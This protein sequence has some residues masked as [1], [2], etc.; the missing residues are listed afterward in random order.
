MDDLKLFGKSENQIDSL[1]W[2]EYLFS[3]G[4]GMEFG[5][6]KCAVVVLKRGKTIKFDGIQLP[7]EE[8]MK[9]VDVNG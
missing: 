7:N 9:G 3:E 2:T 4:I 8:I 1:V 6:K 5:L